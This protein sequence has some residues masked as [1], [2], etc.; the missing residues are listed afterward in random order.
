M[1]VA[2]IVL[3]V[4]LVATVA[5]MIPVMNHQRK[6]IG[7]GPSPELEAGLTRERRRADMAEAELKVVRAR[8][9]SLES[10]APPTEE[11]PTP[12]TRIDPE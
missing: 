6:A 1:I 11:L 7:R 5:T 2:V 4:L 9:S 8:L 10:Q 3:A 12:R